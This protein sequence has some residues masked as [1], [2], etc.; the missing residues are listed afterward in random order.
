MAAVDE[1]LHESSLERIT[2][3][4]NDSL[5]RF[6]P[7]SSSRSLSSLATL[8]AAGLILLNA[9][10]HASV[11]GNRNY[12]EDEILIV[13]MSITFSPAELVRYTATDIHPPGWRLLATSWLKFLGVSEEVGRWLAKLTNLITFALIYRLGA[14]L[15]GKRCGFYAV[16]LLGLYGFASNL[17]YELRPYP[18]MIMLTLALHLTYL[19]WLRHPSAMLMF[20][21]VAAGIGAVYT[22]FFSVFVFPAHVLCLPLFG[23]FDRKLW[24]NSFLMWAF[25]AASMLGWLLPLLH[26]LFVTQHNSYWYHL[27]SGLAGWLRF[28]D[29]TELKPGYVYYFLGI[30]SLISFQFR[31]PAQGLLQRAGIARNQRLPA[32]LYPLALLILMLATAVFA[33]QFVGA[34]STRNAVILAPLVVMLMALGLVALP[35]RAALLLLA[36]LYFRAPQNISVLTSN[37]P[38][39]EIVSEMS[40]SYRSDSIVV[41]EFNWAWGRLLPAA[42]YLMDFTAG[43][44]A[45]ER[46]YHVVSPQDSAVPVVYPE[47]LVNEIKQFDADSFE[48]SLPSHSQLWHVQQGRGNRHRDALQSWL[49]QNYAHIRS[50]H[51]HQGYPTLYILSEYARAPANEGPLVELG[52]NLRL[53][54][55]DMISNAQ[56]SP[57]QSAEIESWWQIRRQDGTPYTIGFILTGAA[58]DGQLGIVNLVSA[59]GFTSDWSPDRYYRDSTSIEIPCDIDAGSYDL[60]LAAKESLTGEPLALAYSSG[61]T[62]G[63][64]FYLTTLTVENG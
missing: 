34:W 11:Y 21:Y 7:Q 51:W 1:A 41:T 8:M 38:Y 58:D 46:M 50:A 32:M 37:G 39:R 20:V 25:I 62:V 28:I 49:D 4:L 22:H 55:W 14:Q 12:R 9:L 5:A 42:Y 35:A 61:E 44:I 29:D 54:A 53:Y 45:N 19:R 3:P 64:E 63:R 2:Q 16:A 23:R 56:L 40:A 48:A 59:D 10:L 57:C 13:H 52:D 43:G 6:F 27:P 18:M 24:L 47:A 33:G 30:L 17:M 15:G 36:L 26:T 31:L 60:L